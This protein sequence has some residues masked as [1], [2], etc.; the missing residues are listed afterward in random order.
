MHETNPSSASTP[1]PATSQTDWF[2]PVLTLTLAVLTARILYLLLLNPYELAGDEAQYWD[3]SRRLDW[4]Y[5]SKGPG[6]AWLIA[7]ST[8]I[9]GHDA[10]AVRLPAAVSAAVTMLAA[11][12]IA[13][14]LSTKPRA[15]ALTAAVIAALVPILFAT[16]QFITIDAPFFAAWAVTAALAVEIL[17]SPRPNPTLWLL[18]GITFG[19]GVLLK[20]T[21]LLI[22]PGLLLGFIFAARARPTTALRLTGPILAAAAALIMMAPIAIWN[23]Q[24]GW[25][26]LAHLLGHLNAPGGDLQPAESWTYNPLW[27]LEAIA[28]QILVIA[29]GLSLIAWFAC[30]RLPPRSDPNRDAHLLLIHT[31]WPVYA[32]YL[33]VSLAKN[34][35]ANWPA[36]GWITL[37]PLAAVLITQ[38][39]TPAIRFGD[40]VILVV[41]L[42][43][44]PHILFGPYLIQTQGV[45]RLPFGPALQ[46]GLNRVQGMQAKALTVHE[47]ALQITAETGTEP[48]FLTNHYGQ[49]ALLAYYLPD[50][51]TV[52]SAS[53]ALGDRESSY[54]YFIDTSLHRPDLIGKP[55]V[56]IGTKPRGWQR[57]LQFEHIEIRSETPLICVGYGYQGV[58]EKTP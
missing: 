37:I 14:R 41:G 55:A 49:T 39:P 19:L 45:D 16:A 17:R 30:R 9:F 33:L 57:G 53:S 31:A 3:W 10:W 51:P 58:K 35:E 43:A 34:I 48:W 5:Y 6:I 56:M 54:D 8:A 18:L 11:A 44:G 36:A 22:A 24:N 42:I 15:A 38:T 4:S 52:F 47:I 27:T 20:Y 40:R 2:R 23:Q 1:I 12:A 46:R 7:A 28:V 26:T 25:P 13:A 50:Q 32:F 29:P 21:M